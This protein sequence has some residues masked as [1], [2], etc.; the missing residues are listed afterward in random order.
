MLRG[1]GVIASRTVLAISLLLVW[2]VTTRDPR[3]ATSPNQHDA[4]RR[5]CRRAE[6]DSFEPRAETT[7]AAWA[8]AGVSHCCAWGSETQAAL[9]GWVGSKLLRS[10]RQAN[11]GPK[12]VFD[13]DRVDLMFARAR[14]TQ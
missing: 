7:G 9:C 11:R 6:L 14:E 8:R 10:I 1:F 3:A 13:V 5:Q 2:N 4:S 12:R